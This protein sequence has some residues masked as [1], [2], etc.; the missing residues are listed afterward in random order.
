MQWG[1]KHFP[2]DR[3]ADRALV[4]AHC[5]QPIELIM[6]CPS[7]EGPVP[8]DEITAGPVT[9]LAAGTRQQTPVRILE[10]Q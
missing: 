7:C 6:H 1:D 8:S 2:A 9:P 5:D 10:P 3:P 4:H